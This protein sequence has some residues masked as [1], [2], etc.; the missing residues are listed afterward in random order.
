MILLEVVLACGL[1][2]VA[3][4]VAVLVACGVIV[5]CLLVIF[6]AERR[7]AAVSCEKCNPPPSQGA[8]T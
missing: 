3:V 2:L 7:R 4:E 5:T 8:S 1:S 6:W